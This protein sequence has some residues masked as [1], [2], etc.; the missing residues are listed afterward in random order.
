MKFATYAIT[1]LSAGSIACGAPVTRRGLLNLD[2]GLCLDLSLLGLVTIDINKSRCQPKFSEEEPFPADKHT[3]RRII[4]DLNVDPTDIYVHCAP[5]HTG[6]EAGD[7][8]LDRKGHETND[9]L[10]VLEVAPRRGNDDYYPPALACAPPVPT[11][12]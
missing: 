12:Y 3:C 2:L 5:G 9:S 1:L 7:V 6:Q 10:H 8:R 4:N 11:S